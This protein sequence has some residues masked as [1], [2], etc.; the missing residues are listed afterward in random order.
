M[1]RTAKIGRPAEIRGGGK[2]LRGA[3]IRRGGKILRGGKIARGAEIGR[4]ARLGSPTAVARAALCIAVAFALSCA[5]RGDVKLAKELKLDG[6]DAPLLPEPQVRAAVG[7]EVQGVSAEVRFDFAEPL[8]TVTRGCF[9]E[10]EFV[11]SGETVEVPSP[12]GEPQALTLVQLG[13][14]AVAGVRAGGLRAGMIADEKRCV[15][16]IGSDVL[17]PYAVTIDPATRRVRIEKSKPREQY[18]AA[19][20]EVE[21]QHFIDVSRDP[22]ADW[23]M[24]AIRARQSQGAQVMGAFIV[25]LVEPQSGVVGD[26]A[27]EAGL[28]PNSAFLED[29]PLPAGVKLPEKLKGRIFELDAL[30]LS[31]GFGLKYTT[32]HFMDGWKKPQALGVVGSDVW[33]RFRATLDPA[34]GLLV[35]RR[36]RVFASGERQQ[37]AGRQPGQLS[38]EA[39][40]ELRGEKQPRGAEAVVTLWRDAPQGARVYLELLD[41]KGAAI[42]SSCRVGI[43]FSESDRG[44]STRHRF[45]WAGLEQAMP[46]CAEEFLSAKGVA[47][48]L[49]EEGGLREC[50]GQCGFVHDMN[51][52][53]VNC[54]CQS[55]L[56]NITEAER[57]YLEM[58]RELMKR[59]K[60]RS[61]SPKPQR[62]TFDGKSRDEPEPE[63]P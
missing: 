63:E 23:P 4:A 2:I 29:L 30:E 10:G 57:K 32:L 9:E 44:T 3:E 37:C 13:G 5:H 54:E 46:R 31:P 8:T 47:F 11:D 41:D 6:L 7:G 52:G 62:P 59:A 1:A 18:L 27:A 15:L 34:A 28:V 42:R 12:T 60:D 17:S 16:T 61:V 50:P 22:K 40:F 21:E 25:S 55:V 33:G 14:V 45:P 48:G 24:I 20:S 39:C 26:V 36:P 56:A 53:R 38:E 58:Y 49:Y 43:T 51:T 35:L 19:Q